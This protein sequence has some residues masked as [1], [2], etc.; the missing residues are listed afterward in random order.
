MNSD[1]SQ[2]W[3]KRKINFIKSN[4]ANNIMLFSTKYNRQSD[5]KKEYLQAIYGLYKSTLPFQW[6]TITDKP[7]F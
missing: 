6:I 7:P 1:V 2:Q 3:S 5:L 4:Y